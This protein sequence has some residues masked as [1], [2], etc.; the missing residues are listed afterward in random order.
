MMPEVTKKS[1]MTCC[2]GMGG[3]N[4]ACLLL[5]NVFWPVGY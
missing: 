5:D 4:S 3:L 2:F 1:Q